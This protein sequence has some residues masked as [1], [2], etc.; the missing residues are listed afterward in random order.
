MQDIWLPVNLIMQL[1]L[2]KTNKETEKKNSL[3]TFSNHLSGCYVANGYGPLS[4]RE[5]EREREKGGGGTE[6]CQSG[7]ASSVSAPQSFQ[8]GPYQEEQRA[9]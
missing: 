3:K 4:K 2:G 5:R 9:V 6:I 7:F 1:P 8:L